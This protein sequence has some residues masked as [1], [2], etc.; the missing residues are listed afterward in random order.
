MNYRDVVGAVIQRKDR[1]LVIRRGLDLEHY[2][3]YWCFVGGNREK[4]DNTLLDA[5]K[6]EVLEEL[7]VQCEVLN[8]DHQFFDHSKQIVVTL[9]KVVIHQS[10]THFSLPIREVEEFRWLTLEEI[11][12]QTPLI[13]SL[14]SWVNER[15]KHNE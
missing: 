4:E 15:I 12:H 2:A 3:G 11:L 6:R 7:G 9:I 14:S 5:M 10:E 13:P 1:F 8:T